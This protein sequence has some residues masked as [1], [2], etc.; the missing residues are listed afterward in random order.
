MNEI[1][2]L[3]WEIRNCASITE[4]HKIF[5]VMEKLYDALSLEGEDF[6][7]VEH[8][9]EDS[10]RK[11]PFLMKELSRPAVLWADLNEILLANGIK[12]LKA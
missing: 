10:E 7:E 5:D 12:P 9:I 6:S 2:K 1:K 11:L 3:A 8:I 4:Y